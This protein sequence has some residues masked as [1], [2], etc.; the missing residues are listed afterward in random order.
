MVKHMEINNNESDFPNESNI[1]KGY[2]EDILNKSKY[3]KIEYIKKDNSEKPTGVYGID[4]DRISLTE[5]IERLNRAEAFGKAFA[6]F[7]NLLTSLSPTGGHHRDPSAL[8]EYTL[9]VRAGSTSV[10]S[11]NNVYTRAI[12]DGYKRGLRSRFSKN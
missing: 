6:S 5:L 11:R 7:A 12:A 10:S 9:Q 4:K 2:I 8:S 3:N 1:L